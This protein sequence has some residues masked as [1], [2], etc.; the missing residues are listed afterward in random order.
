[1]FLD[2]RIVKELWA[3]FAEVRILKGLVSRESWA[4]SG[5]SGRVSPDV[6]AAGPPGGQ[7]SRLGPP[8]PRC[9]SYECERK[10]VAGKGCCKLM[11]G[12]G[13]DLKRERLGRAVFEDTR[14]NVA[15]KL[16][17]VN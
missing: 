16:S 3:C 10:G 7:E 12:R 2:L 6:C 14:R 11:K 17:L 8:H 9:F 4:V 15:W 13:G 5:G 1:M